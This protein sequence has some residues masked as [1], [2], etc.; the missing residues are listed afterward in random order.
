MSMQNLIKLIANNEIL[1][2]TKYIC[3]YFQQN[4]NYSLLLTAKEKY[5][6]QLIIKS[7]TSNI[8][9]ALNILNSM[10]YSEKTNQI[11]GDTLIYCLETIKNNH[12]THAK[13]TTRIRSTFLS[14]PEETINEI[15]CNFTLVDQDIDIAIS[16]LKENRINHDQL[17]PSLLTMKKRLEFA[18]NELLTALNY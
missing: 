18:Y 3:I 5:N 12:T 1:F 10:I 13:E 6:M 14:L 7:I 9:K 15:L 2:L 16:D 8:N 11:D 4:F 17:I